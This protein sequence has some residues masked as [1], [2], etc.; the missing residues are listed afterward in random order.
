[1][2]SRSRQLTVPFSLL[3][4]SLLTAC[5]GKENES[6]PAAPLETLRQP[7]IIFL[8]SDDQRADA[9]GAYGN[10]EIRTPDRHQ[11]E[12]VVRKYFGEEN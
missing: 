6:A 9:V 12:W 2:S 1:M 11:P 7:N 3:L 8:L 5:A 10:D 4:L